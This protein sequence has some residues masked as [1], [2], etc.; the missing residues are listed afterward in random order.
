MATHPSGPRSGRLP[1]LG[2]SPGGG[3]LADESALQLLDR[4][5]VDRPPEQE[6]ARS[7][8]TS[9]GVTMNRALQLRVSCLVISGFMSAPAWA[10]HQG[11]P[12]GQFAVIAFDPAGPREQ[13]G[14]VVRRDYVSR[15]VFTSGPVQG[16][17]VNAL[18]CLFV[19]DKRWVCEGEGVF[20]GTIE[21]VG[22]G[23][24]AS[25]QR[26]TCDPQ[27]VIV[28][29]G[30]FRTISG[31]GDLVGYRDVGKYESVPGSTILYS[32]TSHELR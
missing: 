22:T 5:E 7:H 9:M 15:S 24:T 16:S 30:H 14:V 8:V 28:C 18:T 6:H 31:T 27:P 21:G 26:F 32:Y 2:A 3:V 17:T 1:Q 25:R 29:K 12:T 20:T 23:T 11:D 19:S 4:I 13:V 10:D